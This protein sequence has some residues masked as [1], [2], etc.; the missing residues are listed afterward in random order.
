MLPTVPHQHGG[1][2]ITSFFS[3]SEQHIRCSSDGKV[4]WPEEDA[5]GRLMPLEFLLSCNLEEGAQVLQP[6]IRRPGRLGDERPLVLVHLPKGITLLVMTE[7]GEGS[8]QVYHT[9]GSEKRKKK[10]RGC[11]PNY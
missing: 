5:G 1:S 11:N 6:N 3:T 2:D 7:A 10:E 4:L 9:C 8:K